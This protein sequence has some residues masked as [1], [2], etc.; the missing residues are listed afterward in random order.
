LTPPLVDIVTE[1]TIIPIEAIELFNLVR[2]GSAVW[3][4]EDG[5]DQSRM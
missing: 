1:S 2:K 5:R 3:M 4:A